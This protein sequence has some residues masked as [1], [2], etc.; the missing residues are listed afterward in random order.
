[1]RNL[2]AR[3]GQGAI[4]AALEPSATQVRAMLKAMGLDESHYDWMRGTL[5]RIFNTADLAILK[6]GHQC[7]DP[8]YGPCPRPEC[9]QPWQ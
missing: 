5:L 2:E 4:A 9:G 3:D 8:A 6:N 1:M 7:Q